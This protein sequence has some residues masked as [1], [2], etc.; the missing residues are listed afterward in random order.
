LYEYVYVAY[1]ASFVVLCIQVLFL[2]TGSHGGKCSYY[3]PLV[4]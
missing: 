4:I 3:G 2:K 1:M